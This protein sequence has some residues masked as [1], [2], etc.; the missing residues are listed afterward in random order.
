[1][2][3]RGGWWLVALA[4]GGLS[5]AANAGESTLGLEV[6]ELYMSRLA[7]W[8]L[9]PLP[10]KKDVKI[11]GELG[12]WAGLNG[13]DLP[14]LPSQLQMAKWAGEGD[15]SARI[16]AA[17]DADNLYLAVAV[18]DDAHFPEGGNNMWR[19]D[20]IQIGFG[21]EEGYAASVAPEAL[22]RNGG[23]GPEFGVACLNDKALVQRWQ[24]GRGELGPETV[25]AAV[26]RTGDR[27]VYE[28]ALPWKAIYPGRPATPF[29]FN[30]I[31]NDNDGQNRR[32][33]IEMT[34]GIGKTK[35]PE[36][37]GLAALAEPDAAKTALLTLKVPPSATARGRTL[38]FPAL[39]YLP[40]REAIGQ[41]VVEVKTAAG[42]TVAS[43]KSQRPLPLGV[44]PLEVSWQPDESLAKQDYVVSLKVGQAAVEK[45]VTIFTKLAFTEAAG[46]AQAALT[47]LESAVKAAQA[48]NRPADYARAALAIGRRFLKIAQNKADVGLVAEAI[49][50][51]QTLA[52]LAAAQTRELD[53][54][55]GAA[56][57]VPDPRLDRVEIRDGNFWAEGK[58]VMLVGAMG[59]G[60]LR[61]DLDS[62]REYGFNNI[63]GDFYSQAAFR[64]LTGENQ[65]DE[66]AI[67]GL[68]EWTNKFAQLNLTTAFN[69]TLHYFPFWAMKKYPDITG[70]LEVDCLPDWS[71]RG[72][73]AGKQ[74]KE[75]GGFFPFAVDSENLRRLV[76]QY[77]AKL[78]PEL[79]KT[80]GFGVTWLM[81]EPTYKST[82]PHYVGM[83]RAYLEKKYNGDLAAL[84]RTWGTEL[85]SFAEAD[86]PREPGTPAKFDWLTFHQDQVAGWFEWLAAEAKKHYP[87]AVLS[88]KPMA[89][90]LLQPELGI[91]FERE[92]ELWEVPG[93]DAGRSPISAD[94][95]FDW[96]EA[97]RLFDFQKSIAPNKPLTDLEYHY[98]HWPN[99]SAEYVRATYFH[100]YLHGL[101]KSEFWYW[102][103]GTLD[104][105]V[106]GGAGSQDTAWSQPKVAWGTATAALDLRRLSPYV[107]AFPGRP[108]AFI[109]F[110]RPSLYLNQEATAKTL[111]AV[112]EAANGLDAPLGFA[113]DKLIRSGRLAGAK[114]LIVPG[115]NYVEADVLQKIEEF[116]AGGGKV[117]LVNDCLGRDEYGRP[118]ERQFAGATGALKVAGQKPE[119]LV[120]AC[121][122][123]LTAAGVGRPVRALGQDGRPAWPVECRAAE[124]NG[125]RIV[126]L[127]GLNK[128][129]QAVTLKTD[130][131]FANWEDLITGETGAAGSLAVQPLDVR[132][133]RLK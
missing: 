38:K 89:W 61:Q 75:Y 56:R 101:R 123:A 79:A 34:P 57:V 55:G 68:L 15:L 26:K 120:A 115:A 72:M 119:E 122:A 40:H 47:A 2:H 117:L 32:G 21:P 103:Q 4:W 77:Y 5:L 73:T 29:P 88:N 71:G 60:E 7:A 95:S 66:K 9:S 97:V 35:A 112:Y 100:S 76:G 36:Q 125:E 93:C 49:A 8:K 78:M 129:T 133:L 11:D 42:K 74:T 50:D 90:T 62:Y 30:V 113:T 86:Y 126:Y 45:P 58:P 67:P 3:G 41:A 94:Y 99:V 44:T 98:V 102:S 81:N 106:N 80:P 132:L 25:Q 37:F 92:A 121:E 91:D 87:Q 54:G 18:R 13:I 17:W 130:K 64:M 33:W 82:D 20:S 131:P 127:I 104:P 107:A 51:A 48:A 128:T 46:P 109:Y 1:M 69:P 105:E 116:A 63:D 124:V 70:G 84:N 110:S 16:Q 53:Q 111:E 12:E 22:G 19:G 96:A 6:S 83:F 14:A 10:E 85:K 65:F 118:R 114:L 59:F 39:A 52:E 28:L 24:A 108:E 27:T 31:V 43:V 23:Y